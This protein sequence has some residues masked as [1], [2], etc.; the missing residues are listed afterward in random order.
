MSR[1]DKLNNGGEKRLSHA[2]TLTP[3]E[4]QS[5]A[6]LCDITGW[7]KSEFC[8]AAILDAM[9]IQFEKHGGIGAVAN[10]AKAVRAK[11]IPPVAIDTKPHTK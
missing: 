5:I 1:L 9:D 8:R 4:T 6:D 11:R 3:A 2:F 10:R 7:R